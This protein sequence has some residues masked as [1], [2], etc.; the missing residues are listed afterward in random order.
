MPDDAAETELLLALK[1]LRRRGQETV[2]DAPPE[3]ASRGTPGAQGDDPLSTGI[4][5]EAS[6]AGRTAG[7]ALP[8]L[9]R[10]AGGRLE[11]P[12]AETEGPR[13][14]HPAFPRR[15]GGGGAPLVP[16]GSDE[17]MLAAYR[18]QTGAGEPW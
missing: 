11:G 4:E 9:P 1:Q 16:D 3:E 6:L 17:R 15:V 2:V 13:G 7:E 14:G 5:E 12:G 8:P 10:G 18:R